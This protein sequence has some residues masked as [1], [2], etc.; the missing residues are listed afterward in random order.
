M[1]VPATQIP[2]LAAQPDVLALGGDSRGS[3]GGPQPYLKT[4][5][6]KSKSL[7]SQCPCVCVFHCFCI[8]I[9]H[10]IKC[11]DSPVSADFP[12]SNSIS[13]CWQ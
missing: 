1:E 3:E 6:Q 4:K 9:N 13:V 11:Y 10:W 7:R 2:E 12:F 5:H 8:F